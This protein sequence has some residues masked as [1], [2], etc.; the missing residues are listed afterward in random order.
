MLA[1]LFSL[2]E[3]LSLPLFI[4]LKVFIHFER[5][6]K[7][8]RK[9]GRETLMCGCPSSPPIGDLASNPG[10]CP[11]WESNQ[12]SFSLQAGT[13]ST[14][15]HQPGPRMTLNIKRKKVLDQVAQFVRASSR[16]AKVAGSISS[17][18][19]CKNQLMNA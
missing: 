18:G 15:P 13:Q 8:R 14:E 11:D 19:N 9:R 12:R 5:E 7:G 4:F 10:T 17:Q 16:Y 6:V 3:V 1:G 2:M